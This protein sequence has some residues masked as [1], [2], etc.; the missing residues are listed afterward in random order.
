MYAGCR[1]VC[2]LCVVYPST[3]L[4][5]GC[6]VTVTT[7]VT[8]MCGAQV[9]SMGHTQSHC[10]CVRHN[11]TLLNWVWYPLLHP[12]T[13]QNTVDVWQQQQIATVADV[14][15]AAVCCGGVADTNYICDD[16]V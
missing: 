13:L 3:E 6:A 10:A 15:V 7:H 12:P 5:G 9:Y 16:G 8:V 2:V 11:C 14:V 4:C 1:C